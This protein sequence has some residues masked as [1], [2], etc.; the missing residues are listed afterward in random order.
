[1][2]LEAYS[3]YVNNFAKAMDTIKLACKTHL[4]FA[5]LLKVPKTHLLVLIEHMRYKSNYFIPI[6]SIWL[7][8]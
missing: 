7:G 8:P 1:M 6:V 3:E 4:A 5:Q 2:V